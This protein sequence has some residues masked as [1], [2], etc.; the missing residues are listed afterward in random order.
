MTDD[1][2][3]RPD[4]TR[5]AVCGLFCPGCAAFIATRQDPQRLGRIAEGW[6]V[7]VEEVRCDGCRAERRFVYCRTCRLVTCAADK[8]LDFCVQCDDYPCAELM[9]FQAARPHR[10]EL[11]D[12]LARI[13]EAGWE[14][15]YAEMVE[16]YACEKCGAMNSAYDPACRSCG[17]EPSCGYVARHGDEV[18]NFLSQQGEPSGAKE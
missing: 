11:W 17:H 14:K 2:P 3:S 6:G 10:I 15:W 9:E 18:R 5:A 7:P 13:K 12:N 16:H 1:N 8:G 4:L